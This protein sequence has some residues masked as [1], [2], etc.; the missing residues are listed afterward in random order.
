MS[1]VS[2]PAVWSSCP[3]VPLVSVVV[4][5]EC[6]VCEGAQVERILPARRV[7]LGI[8]GRSKD[9]VLNE[10]SLNVSVLEVRPL[11]HPECVG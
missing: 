11:S 9:D 6:E 10:T 2:L 4:P 1:S 5:D 8:L 7:R 3:F